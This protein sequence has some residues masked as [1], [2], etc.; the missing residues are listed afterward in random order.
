MERL[1]HCSRLGDAKR[2]LLRLVDGEVADTYRP[3][4]HHPDHIG[5]RIYAIRWYLY[6]ILE[7]FSGH[8][9]QILLLRH[10]YKTAH[11]PAKA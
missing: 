1:E 9:G 11:V 10:L 6:H 4:D 8:Y 3:G 5:Q 7:H 2:W